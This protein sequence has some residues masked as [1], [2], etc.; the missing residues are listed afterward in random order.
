M[1]AEIHGRDRKVTVDAQ[2]T[3]RLAKRSVKPAAAS[4]LPAVASP[5]KQS[6]LLPETLD[7]AAATGLA[8]S[9]LEARGADL[10]IDGSQVRRLGGQ[11]AQVLVSAAKTWQH[12]RVELNIVEASAEF[13]AGLRLLGLSSA[14]EL[15]DAG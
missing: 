2:G 6:I 9:L 8:K 12:D 11:C 3:C 4:P 14:L 15:K 13:Q 7:L 5:D 10:K 1:S